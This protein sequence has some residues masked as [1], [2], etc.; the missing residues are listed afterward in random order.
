M[1]RRLFTF[2]FPML[3]ILPVFAQTS[4]QLTLKPLTPMVFD[5]DGRVF[6]GITDE[7]GNP[8]AN[9]NPQINF[10]PTRFVENVELFDCSDPK[11][12]D[13]CDVNSRAIDGV[14]EVSF[15]I[16]DSPVTLTATVAGQK[17][18]LV[19][20]ASEKSAAVAATDTE[21]DASPSETVSD[22]P[23]TTSLSATPAVK[24][25]DVAVGPM[26]SVLFFLLPIL[27][28]GAISTFVVVKVK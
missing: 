7:K 12:F 14:F 3:L 9:Q 24:P 28:I 27:L 26:P 19:L 20:T 5:E 15:V 8:L 2:F 23:T 1:L 16:V 25:K 22:S 13:N 18:D 21:E 17:Q 4:L 10:L 6:L 11:E